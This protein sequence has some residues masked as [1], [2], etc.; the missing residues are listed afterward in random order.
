M[1]NPTRSIAQA[2]HRRSCYGR[3]ASALS[4]AITAMAAVILIRLFRDI[5]IRHVVAA[6]VA[7]PPRRLFAATGFVMAGYLMLICYDAFALR[8]IGWKNVPYRVAA[9][10]GFTSY[11]IGHNVGAA[12]FTAAAIRYRIYGGCGLGVGDIA[13]IAFITSL[14]YWLGNALVF[15]CGAIYAPEAVTALDRLP[16][17]LN[18]A[19]GF[20]ALVAL[21]GYLLW[22]SRRRR[23]IGRPGWRLVL[24]GPAATLLQTGIG[25][26]DL[27]CVTLA[28]CVLLPNVPA[29]GALQAGVA[30]VAAMLLGVISHVPG[31]LGVMEAVMLLS[32]P[33]IPPEALL[34]SLLTFR[35]LYFVLPLLLAALTLGLREACIAF[36]A[37]HGR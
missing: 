35:L 16:P 3:L 9:L 15:G 14:T 1:S 7:Q 36:A 24:P 21:G 22:L 33:Q 27:G 32:L 17:E 10:A 2:I 19:I 13:R 8:V 18:R 12:V 34:A 28:M 26:L 11:T 6:L 5:D 29:P 20:A 4:L 31:S 37:G 23:I 30:F 25:A